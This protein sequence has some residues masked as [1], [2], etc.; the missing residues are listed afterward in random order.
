LKLKKEYIPLLLTLSRLLISLLIL[1]IF[2]V[3]L[4]P[5]NNEVFNYILAG[6]FIALALT[7]LFD[8][9]LARKFHV[10]SELGIILDPIA[11]KFLV[12]ATL[13]G[14]LAAGKINYYW[15]ILLIGRE[16][17]VMGLRLI[18]LS[19]GTKVPVSKIAKVKTTL[20]MLMLTYIIWNPYQSDGIT[21][22][23][24]GIERVLILITVVLSLV[25]AYF[26]CKNLSKK[27]IVCHKL[28][29]NKDS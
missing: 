14:L 1:P 9:Y 3:W 17:F 2:L 6:C 23:A 4:L 29:P 19:K 13:I 18:A 20:Q 25:S 16:F 24:N 21:E 7:D 10:E 22:L 8:G 11:D 15:V 27:L 28:L 12:Y 5:I 26:Y